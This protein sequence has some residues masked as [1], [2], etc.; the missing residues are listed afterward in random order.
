MAGVSLTERLCRAAS[1]LEPLVLPPNP[2]RSI[3]ETEG[4]L[5]AM[6]TNSSPITQMGKMEVRPQD[7]LQPRLR[8]EMAA[9]I[10]R[11]P[12]LCAGWIWRLNLPTG[13]LASEGRLLSGS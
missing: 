5:G 7:M 10:A 12:R 8:R 4:K 9:G 11:G 13:D 6:W 1:S 3:I 2:S